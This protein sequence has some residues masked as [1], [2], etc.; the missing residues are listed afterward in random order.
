M[1]T[2]SL[3]RLAGVSALLAALS[4]VLYAVSFV[5]LKN[6]LLFSLFLLLGGLF[7]VAVFVELHQRLAS[8]RAAMSLLALLFAALG[9]AGAMAHG[10]FDLANALHPPQVIPGLSDLPSQTDPRGLATFA[11]TGLAVLLWSDVIRK[12]GLLSKGLGY[13]GFLSGLLLLLTYAARLVILD[14]TSLAVLGPALLEG[15]IVN[16]VWYLW[17]AVSFAKPGA[18][19]ASASF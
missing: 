9:A 6:Q 14:A 11:L 10:A 19:S 17:L 12:S 5:I 4:G 8:Q 16:P 15:F 1:K 13:L 2:D 18:G 3:G 7:S